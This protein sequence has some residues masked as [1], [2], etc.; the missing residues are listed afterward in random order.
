MTCSDNGTSWRRTSGT[1]IFGTTAT[2]VFQVPHNRGEGL[3]WNWILWNWVLLKATIFV[4]GV[5]GI[6]SGS[7]GIRRQPS[8]TVAIIVMLA[9]SGGRGLLWLLLRTHGHI[10]V[11]LIDLHPGTTT[12]WTYIIWPANA[13]SAGVI[14]KW[15]WADRVC[16]HV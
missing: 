2:I 4:S 10:F 16:C 7:V 11:R 14:S 12:A 5:K 3:W 1:N 6:A 8:A 15:F 13:I 9:K